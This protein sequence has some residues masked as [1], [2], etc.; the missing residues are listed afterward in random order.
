MEIDWHKVPMKN[1]AHKTCGCSCGRLEN[2]NVSPE[3]LC[4]KMKSEAMKMRVDPV[5]VSLFVDVNDSCCDKWWLHVAAKDLCDENGDAK[6]PSDNKNLGENMFPD[7]E[8]KEVESK[9]D[10]KDLSAEENKE[11]EEVVEGESGKMK[12]VKKKVRRRGRRTR[13]W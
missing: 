11:E 3:F 4:G 12:L 13:Q 5:S 9:G 10:M 8:S 2:V 6:G 1:H 7:I